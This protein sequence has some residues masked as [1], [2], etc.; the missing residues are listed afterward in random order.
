MYFKHKIRKKLITGIKFYNKIKKYKN[1][2][3]K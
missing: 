1:M 3:K 2:S